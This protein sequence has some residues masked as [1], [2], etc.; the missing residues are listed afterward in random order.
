MDKKQVLEKYDRIVSIQSVSTDS[1]RHEEILKASDF[2]KKE[3]IKMGCYVSLYEKKSC[4]PLIIGK[5]IISKSTTTHT[6]NLHNFGICSII[7]YDTN[8][9]RTIMSWISGVFNDKMAIYS[10]I[11]QR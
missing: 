8:A 5:K 2:I 9:H 1:K 7:F 10:A 6:K 3:L 4:P 11:A